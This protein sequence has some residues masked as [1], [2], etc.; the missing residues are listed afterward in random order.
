[1]NNNMIQKIK[2]RQVQKHDS[3]ENWRKAGENGFIPQDGEIIVYNADEENEVRMK[4]GDGK[5]NINDLPFVSGSSVG[6][7][8]AEDGEIFNDYENNQALSLSSHAEG[9][10]NTAGGKGFMIIQAHDNENGTG[11]YVLSSTDGLEPGMKYS[12][13]LDRARLLSGQIQAIDGDSITVDGYKHLDMKTTYTFY[14]EGADAVYDQIDIVPEPGEYRLAFDLHDGDRYDKIVTF[15]DM[16]NGKLQADLGSLLPLY[17]ELACTIWNNHNFDIFYSHRELGEGQIYPTQANTTLSPHPHEPVNYLTIYGRPDLGDYDIGIHAHAEGEGTTAAERSSHTEG[18]G[19]MVIGQYGHAE[20]QGSLSGYAAHAEGRETQALGDYSHAEGNYSGSV[21]DNSAVY[22]T[23]LGI[24]S[25]AEGRGTLAAGDNSH[26]EGQLTIASGT[27][28]HAEGFRSKATATGAHAEGSYSGSVS[29]DTVVPTQATNT[30]AHAEGQGTLSEGIGSHS[31]GRSTTASGHGSHAEGISTVAS[32]EGSHAEGTD[33]TDSSGKIYQTSATKKGAHAE[34]RGTTASGVGAHSEGHRT[35]ASADYTHAEGNVSTASGYGAHAEGTNTKSEGQY[36]HTEGSKTQATG[37]GAHAEG[38][39]NTE[40]ILASGRGSHA[41]GIDGTKATN[42]GAHAEGYG[43]ESSAQASHS[44]GRKTVAS[45]K[46]AHAE[47]VEAQAIGEGSH[48]EG[49]WTR[50]ESQS[51]HAE[52]AGSLA[53]GKYSHAQNFWTHAL[54]NN[55]HA[56]GT[57]TVATGEEQHVQGRYN[58][59]DVIRNENGEML[60]SEGNVVTN[61]AEAEAANTYAVIVG[62][63]DSP[64]DVSNA[65]TL[66]WSGNAWYAGEI[67]DG[68]G[69]KLSNKIDSSAIL[70]GGKIKSDV[71]P[72]Y[73]DD[74]VEVNTYAEL[75]LPGES[76]KIYVVLTGNEANQTYRW[77]GSQYIEISNPIDIEEIN[78]LIDAKIE[79]IEIPSP[80]PE[81]SV[82]AYNAKGDGV[83]DDTKAFKDA[84]AAKRVVI[85]PGGTY[86]LSDTLLIE[87]NCELTLSQDTVLKF[88]QTDKH[89]IAMQRLANLRGNHATIFVPY[90]FNAN[91]IHASTEV[92]S[93]KGNNTYVPPFLKWDPQWKMSRY[94][95]DI[96]ICKPNSNGF[97]YSDSGDCYGKAVYIKCGKDDPVNFMWG[98]NMSG[99]R[100]A[101]GFTHGIHIINV[102]PALECWNHDMRIEGIIDGPETGV[103]IENCHHAHLAVAFQPRK[104]A[105]ETKYVKHGIKLVDSRFIDLG[106]SFVWDWQHAKEG[107]ENTHIAMYGNCEGLIL[108]EPRYYDSTPNIRNSIYTDTPSNLERMVILQEPIDRWFKSVNSVPYYNDGTNIYQIRLMENQINPTDTT[109]CHEKKAGGQIEY[110][111]S[112]KKYDMRHNSY[113]K[114]VDSDSAR[115]YLIKG[116]AVNKYCTIELPMPTTGTQ[117]YYI[118]GIDLS[119]NNIYDIVGSTTVTVQPQ[120]LFS[121]NQIQDIDGYEINE[122]TKLW[123]SNLHVQIYGQNGDQLNFTGEVQG[124]A[125]EYDEDA[126]ILKLVLSDKAWGYSHD[127]KYAYISFPYAPGYDRYSL[128]IADSITSIGHALPPTLDSSIYAT[129]LLLTSPNGT[130]YVISIDDSGQLSASEYTP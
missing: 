84:L 2:A 24:A 59:P 102:G 62:N 8:T 103:S 129:S 78:E 1:M 86:I 126:H 47:G 75:P 11:T 55:S 37:K 114:Y 71:L 40:Y 26:A 25:H 77:S 99:L 127:R 105:D 34:G 4:I 106:Q 122:A 70:D 65:H 6:K 74:V 111:P 12:V 121:T 18:K 87:E 42:T 7:K 92:D 93:A 54:G 29:N 85:V 64:A 13:R 58:I 113:P 41:E 33:A 112:T 63:G 91:V 96:N 104:A 97:H 72:S 10:N 130:P 67:E 14:R 83:T 20:G 117:T 110:V 120:A 89:C 115:N 100:I 31:E 123:R 39:S 109:F 48:A 16:G 94:V 23:A 128:A 66:D 22:T 36:S 101:G 80:I 108:N 53:G 76:G 82:L 35:V 81:N 51:S 45:G 61:V 98:V 38:D 32:G 79:N 43:T 49:T 50:A 21:H 57:W 118:I 107:T 27:E 28:S 124:M 119:I 44:E 69:N 60:D 68:K 88:T 52:G 56:E 90:A 125:Y 3:A 46:A 73:V 95:T 17:K 5:T 15:K 116:S 30:A 9:W 19:T